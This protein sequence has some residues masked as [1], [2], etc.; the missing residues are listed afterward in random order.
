MV[1]EAVSVIAGM[2][3]PTVAAIRGACMGGGAALALACDLRVADNTARFSFPPARLGLAFPYVS[4]RSLVSAVGEAQAKWLLFTG[5]AL[6]A[7]RAHWIGLVS[8][9]YEPDFFDSEL[10]GLLSQMCGMSQASLRTMKEMMR[11]VAGGQITDDEETERM[12][13]ELTTGPDHSEGVRRFL[14]QWRYVR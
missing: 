1:S 3:K 6:G 2:K 11:M 8:A 7:E 12:W 9:L 4:L 13:R 5:E 14:E 10:D